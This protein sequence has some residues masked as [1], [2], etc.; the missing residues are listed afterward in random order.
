MIALIDLMNEADK[1]IIPELGGSQTT[2]PLES[3]FAVVPTI[4][5]GKKEHAGAVQYVLGIDMGSLK[6]NASNMY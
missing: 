3:G 4:L 1:L 5:A 6:S 2:S